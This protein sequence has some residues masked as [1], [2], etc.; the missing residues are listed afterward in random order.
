ML[1]L[2]VTV[3]APLFPPRLVCPV[4]L[5]RDRVSPATELGLI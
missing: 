1:V 2:V 5:N 4:V 3:T